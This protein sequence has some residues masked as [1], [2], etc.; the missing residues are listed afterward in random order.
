MSLNPSV[1]IGADDL[2]LPAFLGELRAWVGIESPTADTPAVNRMVDHVEALTRQAGLSVSRTPGRL[3]RGDLL[4]VRHGPPPAPDRKG[5][6]VLAHLDTVHPIGTL[7]GAL[8]WKED[9]ARIFGPGIYDMKSG[10]LMALEALKLARAAGQGPQHPVTILY[11]SDEEM[12]SRASRQTIEQE[13]DNALCV[14][15]VEPARDGGKIVTARRGSAIY[16]ITIK[17][18]AAHAGTRPQ[19]GRSAI[20]AAARLVLELEA[21]NDPAAGIGVSVG[22][23]NGGTTRNTI[24]A[25]CRMQVDVRL[26]D[27]AATGVIIPKIE[28]LR[29]ADPDIEIEIEGGVTRPAY[30]SSQAGERLF[31]H[32][33][34]YA[35]M[36]GY[37]LEAMTS[38]GGSDGNFTAALGIPTLDG[39]GPDGE[40]AHTL[41]E[42]IFPCSVA[43]RTALLA[44]LMLDP[45]F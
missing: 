34:D 44:N 15:V 2:N 4:T 32:A 39:L 21:L 36:L 16:D 20:R 41:V 28:A 29:V 25:E 38:G 40:G 45:G 24:P 8:P 12:G 42:C 22:T 5:V 26:P 33:A 6:L 17:G 11:V 14:L 10:A 18:R 30:A 37:E 19:D 23:I 9:A 43:A 13:A 27:A 7:A 3:G 35:R 31:S 1:R